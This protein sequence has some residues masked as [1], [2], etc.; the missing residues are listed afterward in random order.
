M[1]RPVVR[2][3]NAPGPGELPLAEAPTPDLP[4]PVAAPPIHRRI[5]RWSWLALASGTLVLGTAGCG[6]YASGF[7]GTHCATS[8][9]SCS[10]DSRLQQYMLSAKKSVHLMRKTSGA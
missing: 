8:D 10:I 9:N 3:F 2:D 1:R 4:V 6:N 7:H 5:G